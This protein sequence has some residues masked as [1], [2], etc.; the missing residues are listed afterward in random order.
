MLNGVFTSWGKRFQ[1][2]IRVRVPMQIMIPFRKAR[3]KEPSS[4]LF[5]Y[6]A[7]PGVGFIVVALPA[8]SVKIC[9]QTSQIG[10]GVWSSL[11]S[12][13]VDGAAC[14]A[15]KIAFM[16]QAIGATIVEIP[17]EKWAV[18]GVIAVLAWWNASAEN[19]KAIFKRPAELPVLSAGRQ[20]LR[21]FRRHPAPA[22]TRIQIAGLCD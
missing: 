2:T 11:R 3:V 20:F 8:R 1:R 15:A 18:A 22:L 21:R 4:A 6:R 19:H 10:T 7:R 13:V 5:L 12:V 16:Y 9:I 17:A 14:F